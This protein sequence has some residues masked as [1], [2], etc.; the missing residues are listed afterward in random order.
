MPTKQEFNDLHIFNG[1]DLAR[2]AGD[3]VYVCYNGPAYGRVSHSAQVRVCGIGFR[4]DPDAS[5]W[6]NGGDKV[7]PIWGTTKPEMLTAALAWA[8]DNGFVP[9]GTEWEKGLRD[10]WHPKGSVKRAVA[11]AKKRAETQKWENGRWVSKT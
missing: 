4:T 9:P 11:A 3:K 5:Y 8:E 7:F 6:E 1:S 10:Y 2:M